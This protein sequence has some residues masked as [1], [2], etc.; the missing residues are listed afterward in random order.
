[1]VNYYSQVWSESVK[2]Y[3]D[4]PGDGP[5]PVTSVSKYSHNYT[6]VT[7]TIPVLS[8]TSHFCVRVSL[9]TKV[10]L[11]I[12]VLSGMVQGQP[13]LCQSIFIH[14]SYPD[15]PCTIRGWSR[16]SHLCVKVFPYAKVTLTIPVLS[17]MV[18][19]QPPLCQSIFIHQSYPDHPCTIRGW[20]RASHLCVKVFPYAK[21]TLTILVLYGDGP[22]PAT[23]VGKYQYSL[24][25][26]SPLL[27]LD[28][29]TGHHASRI[30]LCLITISG[31]AC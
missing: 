25:F 23:S 29:Q 31:L 17:G 11:T 13:P 20:S 26:P 1:M 19:G 14:Q 10:T 28:H 8:R 3:I 2:V 9:Y 5:G 27:C 7:V 30:H 4:H 6:K 16:A 21:V 15:H 12:P 24:V 22:G 18:Q